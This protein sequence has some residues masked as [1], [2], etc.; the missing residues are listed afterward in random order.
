MVRQLNGLTAGPAADTAVTHRAAQAVIGADVAHHLLDPESLTGLDPLHA[1]PLVDA[2]PA[3]AGRESRGWV[4]VVPAPG[5]L[6][7]LRGPPAL[8][9][10]AIEAGS[11]VVGVT[12]GIALVPMAIGPAVQWRVLRSEPPAAPPSSYEA[13]R[14]LGETILSAG[15]TLAGLEVAAGP[16]PRDDG[17]YDLGP[18]RGEPPRRR[19]AADRAVRLLLASEYALDSDGG[20]LS[21]YEIATRRR[22]LEAVRD[23]ARIALVA[24]VSWQDASM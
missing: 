15:R 3:L 8:N 14:A 5:K 11:V 9:Q 23:A 21:S 24:A 1:T 6:G 4:L 12:G 10:A 19:V 20:S 7:G 13:E 17:E 22:E 16:G 18:A 2:L